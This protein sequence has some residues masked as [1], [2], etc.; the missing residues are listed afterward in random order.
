MQGLHLLFAEQ[1]ERGELQEEGRGALFPIPF[2]TT[3]TVIRRPLRPPTGSAA[4]P[5]APTPGDAVAEAGENAASGPSG[6][7][8]GAGGSSNALAALLGYE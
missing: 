3:V 8:A 4:Q 7:M 6:P 5:S 1:D 2:A